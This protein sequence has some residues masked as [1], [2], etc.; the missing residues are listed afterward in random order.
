MGEWAG[1]TEWLRFLSAVVGRCKSRLTVG[2]KCEKK[3]KFYTNI[4]IKLKSVV[5]ECF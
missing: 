2:F 4:N 1:L 3:H 5:G